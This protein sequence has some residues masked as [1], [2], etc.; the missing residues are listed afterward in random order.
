[1]KKSSWKRFAVSA[2]I[3][4]GLFL[5]L[6]AIRGG[7][8]AADPA[9]LW[10]AI[11]DALFIPGVLLVAFGLLLF[12]ADGGVFDMLK[13]GIQK[14]LSVIMTKKK[15]ESLPATFYDYKE[16]RDAR[17]RAQLAHLLITGAVFIALAAAALAIY[18][19]YDPVP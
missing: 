4:T 10:L 18:G 6:M 16:M 14:A 19:Q 2:G 7:F 9:D 1:M 12:A 3:G 13:F 17:P 15:R 8:T 5:L 11:C